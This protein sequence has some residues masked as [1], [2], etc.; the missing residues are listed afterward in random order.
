MPRAPGA[1]GAG[2]EVDRDDHGEADTA[3]QAAVLWTVAFRVER[4]NQ[5]ALVALT[6][7]ARVEPQQRPIDA[8]HA[9]VSFPRA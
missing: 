6:E 7:P 9:G 8:R 5:L 3:K 4:L 1:K 2:D